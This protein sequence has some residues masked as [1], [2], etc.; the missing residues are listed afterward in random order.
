MGKEAKCRA[1]YQ[2]TTGAGKLHLETDQ[3]LFRGDFRLAIPL[4]HVQSAQAV[5]GTL[6]VAWPAGSAEFELGDAAP[7]WA[8]AIV[9]PR[10]LLDKLGVKADD[11]V[12]VLGVED[13]NFLADLQRRAADVTLGRAV[14]GA[15]LIF[16]Q[17]EQPDQLGELTG[18]AKKLQPA[19]AI[20]VITPKK[21]PEIADTV[22]MKAG[23]A[24]GLVDIKVA[25]FSDTHTTLKFVIPKKN[26]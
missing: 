8:H 21:R 1:R 3:L 5:K 15:D 4:K 9:N 18:L 23:K 24:A 13:A 26:R 7:A 6:H 22:V 12:A 11:K 17:A 14:A 20:W 2:G 16:F 19:G 25:R 10:S